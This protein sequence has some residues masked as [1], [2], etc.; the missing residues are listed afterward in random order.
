MRYWHPHNDHQVWC[1]AQ[2][3]NKTCYFY[4]SG[5][6][7]LWTGPL[8]V[9]QHHNGRGGDNCF[10]NTG[11]GPLVRYGARPRVEGRLMTPDGTP[12]ANAPAFLTV[13]D[14][15]AGSSLRHLGSVT[16]DA[17]GRF[18]FRIGSGP[19]RRVYLVS[20]RFGGEAS[21]GRRIRVRAR[22]RVRASSKHLRNGNRLVLSGK[23][24][25]PVPGRGVL[26][27][28]QARRE[29]RWQ[30]F[31]TTRAGP[32]RTFRFGYT[33]RRTSGVQRYKL[34]AHVPRQSIYP[35]APGDSKPV[36]VT[37]IG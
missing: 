24:G 26:V 20:R 9:R 3:S 13:E 8:A 15:A 25:K 31:G 36:R 5:F 6:W 37:V 7:Y 16:T 35:Y 33:F 29:S 2:Y 1:L 19:S 14:D 23:V 18:S 28:L 11:R 4:E 12:L 32:K 17:T 27:E 34:R 10:A 21:A 22:V 30:T